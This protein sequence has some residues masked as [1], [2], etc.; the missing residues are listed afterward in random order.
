MLFQLVGQIDKAFGIGNL[1]NQWG[2]SMSIVGVREIE[3]E[4]GSHVEAG[5]WT[6][7][8]MS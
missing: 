2:N 5:S 6:S 8:S 7:D 1:E 4:P 3:E